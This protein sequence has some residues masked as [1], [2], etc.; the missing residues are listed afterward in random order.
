VLSLV[1][2]EVAGACEVRVSGGDAAPTTF[3]LKR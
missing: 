1:A 3:R 2:R